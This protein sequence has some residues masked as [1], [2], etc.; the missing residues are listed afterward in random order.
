M[1]SITLS[2]CPKCGIAIVE[3]PGISIDTLVALHKKSCGEAP[4]R[5]ARVSKKDP[6]PVKEE[7]RKAAQ[8]PLEGTEFVNGVAERLI[9]EAAKVA[10]KGIT[11]AMKK[12]RR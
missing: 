1:S 12:G 4:R 5:V 7:Q 10:A 6:D 8:P 11:D 2:V 3:T 9:K